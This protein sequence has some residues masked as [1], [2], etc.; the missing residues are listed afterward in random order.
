M[1]EVL[2]KW[3]SVSDSW[4]EERTSGPL[5]LLMVEIEGGVENSGQFNYHYS[6]WPLLEAGVMTH[7]AGQ[8]MH[9]VV[10]SGRKQ[11]RHCVMEEWWW[12]SF[13]VS[14]WPLEGGHPI[15]CLMEWGWDGGEDG[16]VR[17]LHPHHWHIIFGLWWG[18]L[19][20]KERTVINSTT[21]VLYGLSWRLINVG[22]ENIWFPPNI[23][24]PITTRDDW[25]RCILCCLILRHV[26]DGVMKM[27]E[28][29]DI[30]IAD[31]SSVA[32]VRQGVALRPSELMALPQLVLLAAES[33]WCCWCKGHLTV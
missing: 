29:W 1:K 5:L 22:G 31:I 23:F 8:A 25:R 26:V 17:K 27:W 2:L 15:C 32:S 10:M 7:H 21:T 13:I 19:N 9:G 6:V 3:G 28:D 12:G 33:I 4:V 30:L 11:P 20:V 24:I 14:R 18:C 16:D